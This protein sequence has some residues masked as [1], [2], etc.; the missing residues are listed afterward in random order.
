MEVPGHI[1]LVRLKEGHSIVQAVFTYAQSGNLQ[2]AAIHATGHGEHYAL[3]QCDDDPDLLAVI[4]YRAGNRDEAAAKS[5]EGRLSRLLEFLTHQE[6]FLLN[7]AV[8]QDAVMSDKVTVLFSKSQ[9]LDSDSLP[10]QGDWAVSIPLSSLLV[11]DQ[12]EPA[13]ETSQKTWVQV[14]ASSDDDGMSKAG[15]VK[16]FTKFLENR[17]ASQ[18][19]E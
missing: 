16:H 19:A 1:W 14:V 3:F 7:V 5:L 8:V 18:S 12:S 9:P 4:G 17:V 15:S 2:N 11:K 6:L 10:G 13:S